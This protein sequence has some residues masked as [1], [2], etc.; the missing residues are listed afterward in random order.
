[1]AIDTHMH[2][3][4]L[5][6]SDLLKELIQ[7]NQDAKLE[8]VINVGLNEQ[9]SRESVAISS[10]YEKFYTAIG[11]HPLYIEQQKLDFLYEFADMSKVV[12]IGEIGLDSLHSNFY[13]QKNYLIRQICI[14]NELQ[15][16]V[17]IHANHTNKEVIRI[18]DY[19]VRPQYGCVFHCFEPCLDVLE[20]L[21]FYGYYVSF[22]GRITYQTAKKSIEIAKLVSDDLFLVETDSPYFSPEPVRNMRNSSSN[23]SYIIRKIA[24]IR[25]VDYEEMEKKTSDNA[26]R[27]F[28]RMK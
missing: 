20:Y 23:I 28:R 17:I 7:V 14:A 8:Y 5:V 4:Q 12:A 3:N 25:E 24:E 6:G 26:K 1:M 10:K 21:M 11:V 18:F 19:Y 27:L 9:T 22:A 13:E 2:I 15:L 16:P